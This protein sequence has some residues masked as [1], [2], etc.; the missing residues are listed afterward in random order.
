[1]STVHATANKSDVKS[2]PY[3]IGVTGG[4][5]T[6]KSTLIK[7]LEKSGA[8]IVDTD[9]LGKNYFVHTI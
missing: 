4:I 8:Q 3:I 7:V 6:G 1:M 9:K 2:L 5:G